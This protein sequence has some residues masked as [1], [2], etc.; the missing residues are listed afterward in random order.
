MHFHDRLV[1]VQKG[2]V[3]II[4]S[5][6]HGADAKTERTTSWQAQHFLARPEGGTPAS[7][8]AGDSRAA[9]NA[10]LARSGKDANTVE[11]AREVS[12][13][14]E[15]LCGGGMH[16]RHAKPYLVAARFLRKYIDVNRRLR[17][18]PACCKKMDPGRCTA[19]A[20]ADRVKKG[21]P[22]EK[23]ANGKDIKATASPKAA[24]KAEKHARRVYLAYF[25]AIESIL[26]EIRRDFGPSTPILLLDVHAQKAGAWAG[27]PRA[28]G[29]R[30]VSFTA[31]AATLLTIAG[32]QDG[33]TVGNRTAMFGSGGFL[34]HYAKQ[35][36]RAGAV[37]F[38]S[39]RA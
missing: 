29:A 25:A 16:E 32:T 24:A 26:N 8:A 22:P 31:K 3:P 1:V 37:R 33:R 20:R 38:L 39:S 30:K 36:K 11:L 6:P 23:T 27:E 21:D 7:D 35:L 9:F 2:T 4:L 10:R 28:T 15:R 17:D 34:G 5:V 18:T 14:I 19:V 12:E 13:A